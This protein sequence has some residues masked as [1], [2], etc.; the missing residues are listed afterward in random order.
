LDLDSDVLV[1]IKFTEPRIYMH[2]KPEISIRQTK[3]KELDE[4]RE[5]HIHAFG[6]TWP[7]EERAKKYVESN[8]EKWAQLCSSVE[9]EF[10]KVTDGIDGLKNFLGNFKFLFLFY[11]NFLILML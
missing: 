4:I 8:Y 6:L 1:E 10:F 5:S 9:T 11:F 3:K 2:A 7:L